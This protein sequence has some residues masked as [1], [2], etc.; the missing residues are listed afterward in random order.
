M[1]TKSTIAERINAEIRRLLGDALDDDDILR[2][3]DTF[4]QIGLNSLMLARL[5]IALEAEFGTDPFTQ[6]TSIVDMHSLD[7][8]WSAYDEVLSQEAANG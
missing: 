6:G 2:G 4:Q 7:D 3:T 8:L 5:V 1:L